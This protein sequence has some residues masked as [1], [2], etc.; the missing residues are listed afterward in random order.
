M[1]FTYIHIRNFKSIRDMEIRDIDQ[2]LILVGKNNTGKTSILD[3]VSA[4]CGSYA[5]RPEDFN[6]RKQA[7][8]IEAEME[9]TAD[10]L[11]M[12]QHLGLVSQYRRDDVWK[13]IFCQRFPSYDAASGRLTFTLHVTPDGRHRYEDGT[14]KNNG[15]LPQILPK[16]YRITAERELDQLQDD[17]LMFQEDDQLRKLRSGRCIFEPAK[18]CRHCFQCIGLINQKKP[19]ELTACETARLLE[20]KIYQ[21]NLN[22]FSQK[23]NEN[24]RKNGGYEELSYTLRCNADELF[25]VEVNA[26]NRQQGRTQPVASLGKGM[27]SIY[28]LSLLETYIGEQNRLP[29][30]IMVE[31]PEIFLHPELQKTCSEIL[32]RLSRKNQVIFKTHSPTLLFNFNS[33][34]IRQVVLDEEHYSVMREKAAIDEI[35]D[36]L[37][38]G[39]ND[40]MGV[41]FLFI[42]EGKQD[43]SRLPLL[44]EKYYSEIYNE[45]GKLLRI[46]IITTNSCTNIKTYA[47]LKY[48]NQLYM[49]DQFLMIRDG[50]GKDP[51]VLANQLCRYYDDRGREDVDKLPRVTRRNVLILKYYSFENYF[52]NPEVMSQLGIVESPKAFYE[53]LYKKWTEY[54]YRLRSGRQIRELLGRDFTGPEDMRDH[55]EVI[56][57]YLRG[58]NL[59]DIFYGKYK[60]RETELLREY[61]R[62]AP[63]EDFK[64]ILDAVDRFVY[65]DSRRRETI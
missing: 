15:Y 29:S 54:L 20:Y 22:E 50:D 63:R 48:M 58:H 5:F 44:L 6:Q 60:E 43:K 32:Y 42:V 34:Q 56:R 27:R 36:D 10:D 45:E 62:L 33:R 13:R 16:L 55:M 38:Y 24:F 23:V 61:I 37:G 14:H 49:R 52:F 4:L 40:L 25:S 3:A 8:K 18:E 39:A 31:D 51:E 28:M 64:D 65:F 57:T 59:Y 53:T 47:N 9:L 46:S 41:S 35:L 1:R 30:I 19:E 11:Q 2:A 12:F 7:V 17:L 26:F 21:L